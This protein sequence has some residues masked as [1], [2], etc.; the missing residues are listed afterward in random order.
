M[1]RLGLNKGGYFGETI[2]IAGVT[3]DMDAIARQQGW[4]SEHFLD[5]P[6]LRLTAL[7]QKFGAGT[8]KIYISAGIHGDEPA[9]PLA[10]RQLLMEHVWPADCELWICPCL[11][12][13][14]FD[15]NRR[16]NGAGVDLNRQYLHLEAAETRAHVVWLERQPRFDLALCLHEDWESHGFYVYEL[17]PDN[18]PSL[19]ELMVER[20]EA[21]CPIDRSEIIEERPAVG[22]IIRPEVDPRSRPMWPEAFYLLTHKTRLSYTLEAPS[23]FP[24]ATRVAAL[25][26]ATRA[27]LG[28]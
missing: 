14:G 1:Q 25:V 4:A 19:A 15:L 26:A 22:G 7:R 8:R 9:G 12:P 21:V 17:N 24:L 20:V 2:K 10:M 6:N 3:G 18:Q 5:T 27:S 11:N 28:V 16:E 13:T 23:D